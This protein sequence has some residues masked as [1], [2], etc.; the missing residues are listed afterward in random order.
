MLFHD[1]WAHAQVFVAD[2]LESLASKDHLPAIVVILSFLL[3]LGMEVYLT[4]RNNRMTQA[5][6]QSYRTNL[7]T[8]LFNDLLMSLLSVS[9][10]LVLAERYSGRGLLRHFD[11]SAMRIAVA[12]VLFDLTIYLWH[13]ANHRFDWLWAF[14]KI[15]HSDRSMN[16]STAFR[17]HGIEVLLT[18]AVKALFIV[19]TGVEAA[20]VAAFEAVTSAFVLFHHANIA[21]GAEKGLSRVFIVPSLHRVHHSARRKEHDSNYGQLFSIWDRLL[22]TML[23]PRTVEIG[24]ASVG[25][26]D[27][28]D[29]LRFGL[30]NLKS[31]QPALGTLPAQANCMPAPEIMKMMIAEAA[32]YKAQM[33]GFAPGCD[34]SDWLAAEQEITQQF[35]AP[36][37]YA[38]I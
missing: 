23:S 24:L 31:A 9:S 35:L 25:G 22:G 11:H 37:E 13:R 4:R 28:L 32:Y 17:L 27:F 8:F 20:L 2:L 5:L 6:R 29:L 38:P 33:R 26:Q 14:H 18:T 7:A 36:K 12:F 19:A 16:V 21:F 15:H 10:L 3:L 1:A 30:P 34:F